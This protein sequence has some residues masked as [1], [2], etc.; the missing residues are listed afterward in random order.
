[1][2]MRRNLIVRASAL[3]VT[4]L[5]FACSQQVEP[6]APAFLTS[7]PSATQAA[8]FS[9]RATVVQATVLGV[10]TKLV[11]T[12]DL[13]AT[14]GNQEATLLD[15]NV[16][17]LLTAEVLHAT[18]VG[19]GNASRS[20]A[21]VARLT[22]T[23][24]GHM[25]AAGFLEARATA[26]CTDGGA[27]ASG[28]SDIVD[29]SVDGQTI[30]VSGQPNQTVLLPVGRIVINEQ[31]SKGSGDI[32]VNALHVIV[33]GVADVIISSAHADITC[34]P[35]PPPPP[36]PGCTP[37]DFITGG[38]WI[39]GTPSGAKGNFGVA[40]G[41][42]HGA[43]WGH[44]TYKDHGPNG[45]TVKGT[46]VTGYTADGTNPNLRHITGNAE[47]NGQGGFT[48]QV[49][50]ADNGEPGRNDTFAITLSP[51]G[52]KASGTLGGGNI[53]LHDPSCQ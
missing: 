9:G 24:G 35:G 23:A 12:G 25:I 29:L 37:A 16:P 27:T 45:P 38:G 5:V 50:V 33:D 51:G 7:S 22:L 53:Q 32:T 41:I 31:S 52:Y 15:A 46:G 40:G 48:Y 10:S 49:D 47:V 3:A 19:Q 20:E 36:P 30:M 28:N 4:A 44:L 14:G 39:T 43:F 13:P 26:K 1:M 34:Q 17:G 18:T 21:S 6:V 2:T 8:T 11:D 42:K